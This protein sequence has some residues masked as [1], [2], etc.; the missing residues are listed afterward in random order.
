MTDQ[1]QPATRQRLAEAIRLAKSHLQESADGVLPKRDRILIWQCFGP[2]TRHMAWLDVSAGGAAR[3]RYTVERE[4]LVHGLSIWD[5]AFPGDRLPERAIEL[6]DRVL[7]DRSLVDKAT[8]ACQSYWHE[9]D[10]LSANLFDT[11]PSQQHVA[12][13][14]YAA[15]RLLS[16]AIR[17]QPFNELDPDD[18]AFLTFDPYR[19][20]PAWCVSNAVAGGSEFESGSDVEARRRFWLW[21][22]DDAVPIA[23]KLVFE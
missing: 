22:L 17:D 7:T 18:P 1:E 23:A 8:K 13:I 21:Y 9:A 10:N 19:E 3:A 14:C 11:D 2:R 12:M 5:T 4:C 20:D 16:V 6:A 15:S